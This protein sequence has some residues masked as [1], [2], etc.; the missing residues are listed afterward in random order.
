MMGLWP[1]IGVAQEMPAPPPTNLSRL[2][3]QTTG[4]N[5]YE[6]WVMAGDAIWGVKAVDEALDAPLT[7]KRRMLTLPSVQHALALLK[8]GMEKPLLSPHLNLDENTILPE[9]ADFRRLARLLM[10]QVYVQL[11]D[12][13]TDAAIDTFSL[14]MRFGQRIQTSTLING[15]VGVAIHAIMMKAISRHIDNFSQYQ[16]LRVQRIAEDFQ[17]WQSPLTHVIAAEKENTLRILES[18]RSSN[19]ALT[20]LLSTMLPEPD[21]DEGPNSP[22]NLERQ[23]IQNL[24]AHISA[25]PASVNSIIDE[26][27]RR[28]RLT[29]DH[30]LL[31]STLPVKQRTKL[32]DNEANTPPTPGAQL[33]SSLA[34]NVDAVLEKYD[35]TLAQMRLLGIRAAINSFRWEYARL[36]NSLSELHLSK[37]TID[38]TSGNP[39]TYKRTGETYEVSSTDPYVK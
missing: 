22:A 17:E 32:P 28:M 8:Q 9:L 38:P 23:R 31:N 16:C 6:D 37:L 24:M 1:G 13:R 3:P 11:A 10:V 19:S 15:L 27:E 30:A 36:P 20:D 12:G 33:A 5:A 18:K 35:R 34:V 2:F 39:F 4:Q 21:E 26:A 25:Q 14:G 29:Y 7:F